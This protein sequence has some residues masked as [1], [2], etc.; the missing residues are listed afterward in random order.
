MLILVRQQI[1]VAAGN[2]IDT[3][4]QEPFGHSIEFRINAEDPEH[5][6]RPS[7]GKIT[8]LTF[9]WRIWC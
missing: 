3:P 8:S 7:P 4:P 1:L 5:N 2:K 6:F 9:S